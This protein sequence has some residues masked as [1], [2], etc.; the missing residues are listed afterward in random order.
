MDNNEI[1]KEYEDICVSF[2]ELIDTYNENKDEIVALTPM[3][4]EIMYLSIEDGIDKE[5]FADKNVDSIFEV[6]DYLNI[7]KKLPP[8]STKLFAIMRN[9]F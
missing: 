3:I 5:I 1:L 8:L 4:I 9:T 7:S 6:L 2:K